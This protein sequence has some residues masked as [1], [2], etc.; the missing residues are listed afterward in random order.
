MILISTHHNEAILAW[1]GHRD[2]HVVAQAH[3]SG[4]KMMGYS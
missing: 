3:A 1:R 2:A 4:P